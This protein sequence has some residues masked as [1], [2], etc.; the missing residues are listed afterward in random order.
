MPF[1]VHE[2]RVGEFSLATGCRFLC[3]REFFLLPCDVDFVFREQNLIYG[4]SSGARGAFGALLRRA[5]SLEHVLMLE[6]DSGFV[7]VMYTCLNFMFSIACPL[8]VSLCGRLLHGFEGERQLTRLRL[9]PL[10][11]LP[12]VARDCCSLAS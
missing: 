7:Q 3:A 6:S 9:R 2:S 12:V 10:V 1:T 5:F 4:G 11:F 8:L